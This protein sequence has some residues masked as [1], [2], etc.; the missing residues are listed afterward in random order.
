MPPL[1]PPTADPPAP[2]RPAPP[3]RPQ[4]REPK[5]PNLLRLLVWSQAQLDERA[6]YPRINDLATAELCGGDD[7]S[8]GRAGRS[9]QPS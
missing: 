8:P 4:E 3:A 9:P 7:P 5:L 2:P 6:S 1:V